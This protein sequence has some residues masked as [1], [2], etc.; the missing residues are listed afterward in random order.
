LINTLNKSVVPKLYRFGLI[1]RTR[2]PPKNTVWKPKSK[3]KSIEHESL[4]F[5]TFLRKIAKER[6]AIVTTGRMKR[7]H[8]RQQEKVKEREIQ[9]QDRLEWEQYLREIGE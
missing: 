7:R 4:Q 6:E 8:Q 1:H 5:S 2:E 3:R 9:K